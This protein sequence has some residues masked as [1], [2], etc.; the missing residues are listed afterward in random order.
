MF[1]VLVATML[2][3]N[4]IILSLVLKQLIE[5]LDDY[6]VETIGIAAGEITDTM[7]VNYE[8]LVA[9]RVRGTRNKLRAVIITI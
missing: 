7:T 5:W 8:L 1:R 2:L 3:R 4:D 6:S 9:T